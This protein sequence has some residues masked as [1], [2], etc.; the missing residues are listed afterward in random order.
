MALAAAMVF[1]LPPSAHAWR[2]AARPARGL[3]ASAASRSRPRAVSRALSMETDA[4][5][6]AATEG[7][8]QA[9]GMPTE[10]KSGF[11]K[12]LHERGFIHQCTDFAALDE[13]AAQPGKPIA[14]YLGFDATAP[15][16]HVGSLLQI[17]ILRHLQRA[18]HKPLV[19]LGG[20]TTKVG[21]P[22][23]K[24]ESRKLMTYETIN[25]NIESISQ[26]FR[27]FLAFGDGPTDAML[28]NND[29]WLSPIKYLDFLRDYG[30]HFTINRM[31]NFE[32]VKVRL[33]REQPLTFLEFNYMILQVRGWHGVIHVYVQHNSSSLCDL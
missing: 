6:A 18:G 3:L 10:F 9:S 1:L 2:L 27:R 16:L 13:L 7:Q 24:D 17:M 11:L 31:M 32:S 12:T 20:G 29:D 33:E 15:S 30:Q 4:A 26:V 22:S 19:L 23:G 28:V 21:D 14:A 5:A 25:G 8:A